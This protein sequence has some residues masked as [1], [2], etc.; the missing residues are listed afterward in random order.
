MFLIECLASNSVTNPSSLSGLL[1]DFI[2]FIQSF[3]TGDFSMLHSHHHPLPCHWQ[4][5]ATFNV[6]IEIQP[7]LLK[8]RNPDVVDANIKI[9]SAGK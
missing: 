2:Q 8:R 4:N 9:R 6:D 1:R 5:T 3:I 7:P